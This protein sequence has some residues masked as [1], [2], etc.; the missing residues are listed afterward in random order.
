MLK[1]FLVGIALIVAGVV[2]WRFTQTS[3]AGSSTGPLTVYVRSDAPESDNPAVQSPGI[4][5]VLK[6]ASDALLAMETNLDDYTARFVKQERDASGVLG[7]PAEISIRA[8]TRFGGD[9][10]QSP[11]R[12]YLRFESPASLQ[13]REVIWAEDLYDG[14][15]AVHEVGMILG[16]KTI[17]LDPTGMI[18]MQGQRYPISEIGLVK[19]VEKLIER[20]EQDRNNPNVE[21]AIKDG[22]LFDEVDCQLIQVRRREPSDSEDDFSV[23]EI[24]VDPQ[25]QL[26]LSY[27]SF[28]W[29]E[30]L[31]DEPPLLESYAYHDLKTNVGLTE[32]DFDTKNSNYG[33]PLF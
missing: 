10:N 28:G 1:K 14:K 23:A 5:D 15:M 32:T 2:V 24:V 6:M 30:Q 19:L 31:G 9:E 18:A 17:W 25:R 3:T 22:H 16:L 4:D 20:G 21:V 27:R 26:I 7:E 33:F 8:Q 11:R 12:I 29:P 13:G